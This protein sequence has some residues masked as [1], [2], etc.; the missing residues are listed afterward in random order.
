MPVKTDNMLLSSKV[1]SKLFTVL[2]TCLSGY[3]Q[4]SHLPLLKIDPPPPPFFD[5]FATIKK[6]YKTKS[7]LNQINKR[8]TQMKTLLFL[9]CIVH[10][11]VSQIIPVEDLSKKGTAQVLVFQSLLKIHIFKAKCRPYVYTTTCIL[12]FYIRGLN[13]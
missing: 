10:V 6:K 11:P 4:K 7:S 5:F 8:I 2:S 12:L 1:I 9:Y 13:A 3:Q